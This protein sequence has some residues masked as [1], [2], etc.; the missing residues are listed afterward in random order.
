MEDATTAR[1]LELLGRMSELDPPPFLMGGYAEDALL[2]GEVT[3]PHDDI[4]LMYPRAEHPMRLAQ[5]AQLGFE[6]FVAIG[7]ASP[8]VPFYMRAELGDLVLEVGICDEEADERFFDVGK[9]HFDLGG[10]E[11][12]A[13]YR[14]H[15]PRDTFEWE[16]STIAGIPVR[17][18]SPRALYAIRAGIASRGSMG[19]LT[20]KQL[21][22]VRRL[23]ETFFPGEPVETLAPRITP[24]A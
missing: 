17:V 8:G 15:L 14:V 20:E 16:P 2:A 3:R 9:L 11:P 23:R 24:L 18:L 13:G 19:E 7:D 12:P 4:D 21:R 6:S 10:R 1:Q 22:S 5:A